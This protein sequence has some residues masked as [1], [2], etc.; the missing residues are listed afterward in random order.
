MKSIYLNYQFDEKAED[1]SDG[2]RVAI[3]LPVTRYHHK[4]MKMED[5]SYEEYIIVVTPSFPS[6]K[7][8]T[9]LS[10]LVSWKFDTDGFLRYAAQWPLYSVYETR[11]DELTFKFK[12]L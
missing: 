11:E 12:K 6:F 2:I 1:R 9:N 10:S 5:N 4:I 3:T 8:P 7:Q